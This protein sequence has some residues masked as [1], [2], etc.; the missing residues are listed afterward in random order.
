M[1][2]AVYGKASLSD[3]IIAITPSRKTPGPPDR[4]T[5][6]KQIIGKIKMFVETFIGSISERWKRFLIVVASLPDI[7]RSCWPAP[8]TRILHE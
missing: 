5:M 6:T 8:L 4:H 1:K 2:S 7:L 3:D